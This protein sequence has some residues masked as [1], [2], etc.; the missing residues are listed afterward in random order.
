MANIIPRNNDF[1][2][3]DDHFFDSFFPGFMRTDDFGVDIK[4]TGKDYEVTA[5]LPGFDKEDLVVTCDNNILTIE[6]NRNVVDEN[7]SEDGKFI[8]RERST[9]SY[10]RQ[11]MLKNI[12]EN[13]TKAAFKN[14]VLSLTI[15]KT[16]ITTAD[17]KRIPIE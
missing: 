11:F 6:A 15:P 4:E 1:L 3:M 5:N 13:R 10:R 16:K 2:A 7:K 14:G 8:R 12:D 17:E 9:R